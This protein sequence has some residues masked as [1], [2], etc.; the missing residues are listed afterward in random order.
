MQRAFSLA[1]MGRGWVSPNPMV[2]CVI[3]SDGMII[4]EGWHRNYGKGHA[5]VEAV[6]DAIS[7][8]NEARIAGATAY[9]TLEPCSH[10]GK[11]PPCADLLI[12]KQVKRVVIA[13]EDPNPLVSGRGMKRLVSAGIE[14]VSGVLEKEGEA[15]N[16]RFFLGI[17]K[18]RP[19]V[20]LKWA[21]TRDGYLSLPGRRLKISG[22]LSDVTVHKWRAEEDAILVGKNTVLTDN[23]KLDVRHWTGRNPVRIVLDRN[24]SAADPAFH[25]FDKSQPT[26][27]VNT[28]KDRLD[29]DSLSRY[30]AM[31]EGGYPV[32]YLKV[33]EE[34]EGLPEMLTKL[35]ASG[36]GSILVEGGAQVL[37]AFLEAGLWDEIRMICGP[38]I[39]GG[40]ASAPPPA[41]VLT[42]QQ[43]I[44]ADTLFCFSS[45]G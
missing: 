20:I 40:G 32:N 8:G 26:V 34:E 4:G 44:G 37:A 7:K 13:G 10:Y 36:I 17:R 12:S 24:L 35:Y 31:P 43:E 18:R 21:Q 9:V 15:L 25:L 6:G 27:W 42:L 38:G 28:R 14:V 19:F 33:P 30:S 1:E 2:G 3:V 23:P 11:T 5:E 16:R 41:G 39:A 45:P 22:A 29:R